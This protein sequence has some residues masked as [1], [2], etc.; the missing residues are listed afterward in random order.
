MGFFSNLFSSGFK[1]P[2][3][4]DN[5]TLIGS[6]AG[7]ADWLEK[8]IRSPYETQ[9]T[10]SIIELASKRRAYI[11]NLCVEVISRGLSDSSEGPVYPGATKPINVFEETSE[12]YKSLK[13]QGLSKETAAVRAVKEIIF[14]GNGVQY[15]ADWESS[16]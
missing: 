14:K 16:K 11:A 7:Q 2:K 1:D 13:S 5:Q 12:Y 8:M 15:I 10:K 4:M 3:S 9:K 6:I